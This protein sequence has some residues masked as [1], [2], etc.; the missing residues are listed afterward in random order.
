[1]LRF[2]QI[3]F[4]SGENSVTQTTCQIFA[5]DPQNLGMALFD[6]TPPGSKIPQPIHKPKPKPLQSLYL[7]FSKLLVVFLYK[8]F[9][10]FSYSGSCKLFRHL[11]RNLVWVD[12]SCYLDHLMNRTVQIKFVKILV[13]K[14]WNNWSNLPPLVVLVVFQG[15]FEI[16]SLTGS[17]MPSENGG[18]RNRSGGM[19]VS[20]A[21]PDGRVVG[22]GVAGLLVAASPVQV[23]TTS[24][25]IPPL[26]S[27][28]TRHYWKQGS[29]KL[30]RN[31]VNLTESTQFKGFTFLKLGYKL[32]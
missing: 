15:R 3:V 4:A 19:S 5:L 2:W 30:G 13:I 20:L 23:P 21:S 26:F 7:Y 8:I 14:Y 24:L 18:I 11:G 1:M 6:P 22:G 9:V 32:M 17:F 25:A 10:F 29:E 12:T 31:R 28:S 16:L 27:F